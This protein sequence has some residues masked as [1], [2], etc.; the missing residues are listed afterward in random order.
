MKDFERLK[1]NPDFDI[2]SSEFKV[3][4]QVYNN[5]EKAKPLIE[6]SI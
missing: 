2:F 3:R 5:S 6:M 1:K 4:I